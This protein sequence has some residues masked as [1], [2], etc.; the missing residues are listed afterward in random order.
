MTRE[1]YE[2]EGGEGQSN[3]SQRKE[4]FPLLFALVPLFHIAVNRQGHC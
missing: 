4:R 2:Q 1:R 3:N